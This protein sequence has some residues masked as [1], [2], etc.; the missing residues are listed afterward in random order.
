MLSMPL[1]FHFNTNSPAFG[2]MNN[3]VLI[4]HCLSFRPSFLLRVHQLVPLLD[5]PKTGEASFLK[6]FACVF[7]RYEKL[8]LSKSI[9]VIFLSDSKT[10]PEWIFSALLSTPW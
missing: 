4:Y 9:N 1:H 8:S 5:K 10:N 3:P 7:D 6:E 2:G